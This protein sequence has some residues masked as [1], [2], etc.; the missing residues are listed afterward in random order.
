LR[1]LSQEGLTPTSCD[2]VLEGSS[3][4]QVKKRPDVYFD[5][6]THALIIEIDENQHAPR[7][8]ARSCGG[9]QSITVSNYSCD[10]EYV[11]MVSIHQVIGLPTFFIRYNPDQYV[12]HMGVKH[13]STIGTQRDLRCIRWVQQLMLMLRQHPP[14]DGLYVTYLYYDGMVGDQAEIYQIDYVGQ[15]LSHWRDILDRETKI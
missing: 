15:T 4:C 13:P 12:D 5:C 10:C 7:Y 3:S 2:R 9:D 1:V 14:N 8:M 11:R 6:L